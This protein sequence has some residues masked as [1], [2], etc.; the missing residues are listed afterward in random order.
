[1]TSQCSGQTS[2][3]NNQYAIL[4]CFKWKVFWISAVLFACKHDISKKKI[5]ASS[6]IDDHRVLADVIFKIIA[7]YVKVHFTSIWPQE[8]MV[9]KTLSS[10]KG[11]KG[12]KNKRGSSLHRTVTFFPNR[13][14]LAQWKEEVGFHFPKLFSAEH[15]TRLLTLLLLLL[16]LRFH[17]SLRENLS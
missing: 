4:S 1:M 5:T 14:H 11:V 2:P 12:S 7:I 9:K 10:S 17:V 13:K 16:L 6:E 15:H 3:K 8:N